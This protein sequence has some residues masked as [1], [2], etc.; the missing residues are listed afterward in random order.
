MKLRERVKALEAERDRYRGVIRI[1]KAD[2]KRARREGAEDLA[3]ALIRAY[4]AFDKGHM[5]SAGDIIEDIS[6]FSRKYTEG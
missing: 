6:F 3:K 4:S 5:V 1:L 2:V